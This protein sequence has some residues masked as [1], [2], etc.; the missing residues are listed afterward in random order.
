MLTISALLIVL[1]GCAQEQ[2]P[3][4]KAGQPD[5]S[6]SAIG[7]AMDESPADV[8]H[9]VC[10]RDAV[11]LKDQVVRA[12]RDGVHLLVGNPAV[13]WGV[14][15][16]H[17]SWEYGAAEGF[18]LSDEPTP[19][20]SGMGPGMVTVVCVPTARSSYSDPGLPTATLTI[21]D[22]DGL[23]VPWE[24]ACGFR[25]QFR[26]DV[27]AAEDEDPVSVVRRVPG[28]MSSDD[29]GRPKYPDSPRYSPMESSSSATERGSLGSWVPTTTERGT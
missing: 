15:L 9:V 25:E 17:D 1:V 12:Q 7:S 23:Y 24:L 3:R 8:A 5:A 11:S 27:A 26:M 18:K 28:V 19:D 21:V 4:T 13:A 16:H 2:T 14:E 29:L 22:P 10:E 6:A 20:T